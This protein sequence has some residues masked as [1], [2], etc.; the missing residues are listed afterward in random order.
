M[1]SRLS[2]LSGVQNLWPTRA[3]AIAISSS[4]SVSLTHFFADPHHRRLGLPPPLADLAPS[5]FALESRK[6]TLQFLKDR[7]IDPPRHRLQR[8]HGIDMGLHAAV[9]KGA[10]DARDIPRMM[11]VTDKW[12]EDPRALVP[13]PTIAPAGPWLRR[14]GTGDEGGVHPSQPC[15]QLHGAGLAPGGDAQLVRNAKLPGP[16]LLSGPRSVIASLHQ[17]LGRITQREDRWQSFQ[18]RAFEKIPHLGSA[19]TRPVPDAITGLSGG[20][21]GVHGF[22]DFRPRL[23]RLLT[24]PQFALNRAAEGDCRLWLASLY[25]NGFKRHA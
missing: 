23:S 4:S 1:R 15:A 12:S 2:M 5:V 3:S 17:G 9:A 25:D 22:D 10:L 20:L 16:E 14:F 24:S 21:L 6:P 11:T 7:D 18:Q 19:G 8:V 13:I